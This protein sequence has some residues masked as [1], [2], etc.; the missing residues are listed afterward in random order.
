MEATWFNMMDQKA[1]VGRIRPGW[2]V[3]ILTPLLNRR[4][5]VER[6]ASWK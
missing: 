5:T 1:T 2:S 4:K 3:T 6:R